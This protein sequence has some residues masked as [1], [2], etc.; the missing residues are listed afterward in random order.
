MYSSLL[1]PTLLDV[2]TC[3]IGATPERASPTKRR[4]KEMTAQ[5]IAPMMQR[6]MPLLVVAALVVLSLAMLITPR[7]AHA[8]TTFTVNTPYDTKDADTSDNLCDVATFLP[9]KQ[10]TL[11]AAIEQANA[12]AGADAIRFNIP[13]SFGTGVKTIHVGAPS[14][15]NGALPTITDAVTIDGY[16]QPGSSANTLAK[17]TNAKL[18]IQLEGSAFGP[19]G[20][21]GLVIN[22]PG[23]VVEGLVINR[24]FEGINV[25][26]KAPDTRIEGNFIGPYPSGTKAPAHSRI[27]VVVFGGARVGGSEPATRNLISGNEDGGVQ[28]YGEGSAAYGNLIGTSKDGESPLGNGF[29]GVYIYSH[30]HNEVGKSIAGYANTIAFNEKDGVQVYS[31]VGNSVRSNSIFSNGGLGIDLMGPGETYDTNL[32]TPND[33]GDADTGEANDL[34]NHPALSSASKPTSAKT[35]VKGKLNSSPNTSFEVQFFSAPKGTS[36]GKK[37]L[38]TQ[39]VKTDGAGNVSLTFATTKKVSLGQN[40]IATATNTATGDTS[41]FSAPRKVVSS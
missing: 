6:K 10:C 25:G 19:Q 1:G 29:D 26:S 30:G 16:S 27:G 8:S 20:D 31:S 3:H 12:T 18:T 15:G 13:D 38:G 37:L 5:T 35:V 32:L 24:F 39:S 40:I 14:P 33:P 4:S 9:G 2:T 34:Q 28:F 22:A 36:E 7:P 21:Y 41:E 23:V 17:G 11:R